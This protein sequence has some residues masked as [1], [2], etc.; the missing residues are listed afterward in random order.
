MPCF[1]VN[2]SFPRAESDAQHDASLLSAGPKFCGVE[3]KRMLVRM[4]DAR[5][6]Q[7]L[8]AAIARLFDSG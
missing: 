5:R 6:H 7:Q 8:F 2:R 3:M 1:K 4:T